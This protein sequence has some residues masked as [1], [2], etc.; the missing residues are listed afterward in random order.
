MARSRNI[1]P[2]FFIN[3]DLV[4]LPPLTRLLFIALWTIADREGRLENRPSQ[5]KMQ[6]LPVDDINT[7]QALCMLGAKGFIE[8]YSVGGKD[9]IQIVN[10]KKHQNPHRDEKASVLPSKPDGTEPP[11][12]S[13]EIPASCKHRACL[14]LAGLIPDS[15]KL[16][17]SKSNDDGRGKIPHEEIRLAYNKFCPTLVPARDLSPGS[18]RH[19][20]LLALFAKY[21][22]H[23]GG[24]LKFLDAL[25]K[26]A[27]LSDTVTN[28]NG[29]WRGHPAN[30]DWLLKE[31]NYINVIEGKYDNDRQGTGRG[32]KGVG[33]EKGKPQCGAAFAGPKP[34][35]YYAEGAF[36]RSD[37]W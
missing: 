24:P 22:N 1:K 12:I 16:I 7:V 34:E 14:I 32:A 25:F 11:V 6:T 17:P 27:E 23:E 37:E 28:R 8:L 21:R 3:A 5:I 20:L 31:E 30:L 36:D 13:K 19:V 9:Y 2:G 18:T 26:R 35:G 10:F 4:E 33:A 29:Q 15:L